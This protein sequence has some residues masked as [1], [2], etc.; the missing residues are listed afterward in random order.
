M[1]IAISEYVYDNKK[2]PTLPQ[3]ETLNAAHSNFVHQ[4]YVLPLNLD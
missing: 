4:I 3:D 2:V 1:E